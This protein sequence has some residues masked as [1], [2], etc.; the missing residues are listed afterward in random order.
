MRIIGKKVIIRD[1]VSTDL[2]DHLLWQADEEIIHLD[3]TVGTPNPVLFFS[4]DTLE[5]VHIGTCSLYDHTGGD[6]Q[7][8]IRIGNKAYWNKGYGTEVVSL[9][10]QHAFEKILNVRRVWLKVLPENLGAIRC[11]EKVGFKAFGRLALSGYE[12]IVME[13]L[14]GAT[15]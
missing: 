4:I 1:V 13:I 11:Y 6:I 12:F 9:L 3:P 14:S 2:L 10:V 5:G 7:L 8:G 15:D